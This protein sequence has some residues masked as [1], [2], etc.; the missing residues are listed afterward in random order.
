MG[1]FLQLLEKRNINRHDS[2]A[3]WK[4]NLSDNEFHHLKNLLRSTRHLSGLDPRDC[5]LYYAEWWKRCYEGGVPSKQMVFVSF[6]NNPL[7]DAEDFFQ[8]AKKGAKLLGVRW[9][10]H[11]RTFYFKTLLQ[12]G[13]LPILHI[14][15]ND[16]AYKTFLL[17][18]LALRPKNIDDFAFDATLTSLLPLS[19]RNDQVYECC[20]AIVQAILSDG[21]DRQGHAEV[22]TLLE[23]TAEL[24]EIVRVLRAEKERPTEKKALR[25]VRASWVLEPERK[26][27]RLYLTIGELS[28]KELLA[29]C[30][31]DPETDFGSPEYRLFYNDELLCKLVRRGDDTYR[32]VWVNQDSLFWEA[33]SALPEVY[34]LD[35]EGNRYDCTQMIPNS[36]RLDR[37]TLWTQ[38]SENQFLLARGNNTEEA[39]AY[40]LGPESCDLLALEETELIEVA[41]SC[42]YWTKFEGTQSV[43]QNETSYQFCTH[44]PSFQWTLRE[45]RPSWMQR[46]NMPVL[47]RRPLIDVTD[48]EGKPIRPVSVRWKISGARDWQPLGGPLPLGVV[49]LKIQVGEMVEYDRCYNI[50]TFDLSASNQQ[51]Q[52]A[53]LSLNGDPF[54]F[55][56]VEPKVLCQITA[57]TPQR[58]H[59]RLEQHDRFPASLNGR[60][61]LPGQRALRFGFCAP[62][63]GI[64]LVDKDQRMLSQEENLCVS[65]LYGHRILVNEENVILRL[66]NKSN[67]VVASVHPISQRVTPLSFFEDKIN[68]LLRLTGPGAPAQIA[69]ELCIR[70]NGNERTC[71]TYHISPYEG[72]ITYEQREDKILVKSSAADHPLW[73]I[74]LDSLSETKELQA[75]EKSAEGW[76][77]FPENE[78]A[79]YF[80]FGEGAVLKPTLI[81]FKKEAVSGENILETEEDFPPQ[82]QEEETQARTLQMR[83][84]LLQAATPEDE[85]WKQFYNCY[86]LCLKYS[87]PLASF[88]LLR[89]IACSGELA[90]KAFVYLLCYSE[91]ES[92][93]EE[94]QKRLEAELGLCFHWISKDDWG[95]AMFWIGCFQNPELMSIVISNL[96]RYFNNLVPNTSFRAITKYILGESLFPTPG[97]HLNS[98]IQELRTTLGEQVLTVL[99]REQPKIALKFKELIPVN[100][101]NRTVKILLKAPTAVA[102]SIA[103][104]THDL[105]SIDAEIVRRNIQ[106]CYQ[107]HPQWYGQAI[108]HCLSRLQP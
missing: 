9:M 97:F 36:P 90:A 38:Y 6:Q 39:T 72:Q 76:M 27:I 28:K 55:A 16:G 87:L 94:I 49:H 86:Q 101:G 74:S 18:I 5:A 41:G 103:G 52:E 11:D 19:S 92:F 71:A 78:E 50:G 26:R 75:L 15:K 30:G 33:Q 93:D 85:I 7:F 64:A 14:R 102:L 35:I 4:Y 81:T 89:C 25:K 62:F 83:T 40:L 56:I 13:G 100:E 10:R 98:A 12:Q 46:A 107:L 61:S 70:Q 65:K 104:E 2:R 60:I 63:K 80:V 43:R 91:E 79:R 47:R 82:R 45:E 105:W 3:L 68:H 20:L 99:P 8:H 31:E 77:L 24:T 44:C 67:P 37:P 21:T 1:L 54:D 88:E 34:L 58:V 69:L 106:Y 66:R 51:F 59:V 29:L 73:A 57:E 53:T 32:P 96:S 48:K 22:L 108:C 17:R 42:L 84:L 95:F 23:E